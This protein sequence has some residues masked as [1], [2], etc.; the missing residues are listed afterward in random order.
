[1]NDHLTRTP[2]VLVPANSTP[3]E[4][5]AFLER[6]AAALLRKQRYKVTERVRFT[7]ME[8]DLLAEH[9][10]TRQRA[11]VECKFVRDPLSA[12]VI[13]LLRGKAL[14]K[15]AD[16]AYL[17]S[18]AQSGKE[19]RGV[20]DEI[21]HS[22]TDVVPRFA[23]VGPEEIVDSFEDTKGLDLITLMAGR[24]K[25]V[26]SAHLVITPDLPTFWVIEEMVGGL[27]AKALLLGKDQAS[28]QDKIDLIR[29][30][31]INNSIFEGMEINIPLED[32]IVDKN[33]SFSAVLSE[34]VPLVIAADT[35]ID[36][37]PCRP[38]D[39]VGRTELQR[40][41]WQFLENVRK[42]STDTRILAL[43]GQSGF[44]KSS[45]LL[46]LVDRFK[47][48]RWKSKFFLHPVDSRA[49]KGPL[50]I[51][52]A[53]KVTLESAISNGFLQV[54]LSQV[55]VD[56]SESVLDA[57][58]VVRCLEWARNNS[59]V[60]VLFFDQFEEMFYKQ[61][62]FPVF[63]AFKRFAFQVNARKENL[64]LGFSW[65]TGITLPDGNPAYHVWHSLAGIRLNL[66]VGRFLGKESSELVTLFQKALGP[67]FLNPLRRRL[68]EQG[69]GVPW[70]LKKLC[71][72]V[73]REIT[74]GVQQ[75]ELLERRLNIKAI[76]DE[77]LELLTSDKELNCL[78][79]VAT[80]SPVDLN[81][82]I[83]RFG[84]E[85]IRSL[86]E[87][88]LVVRT[89]QK[90]AIYWD[91]FRDYLIESVIPP[92][93][94]TFVPIVPVSM[95]IR[96]FKEIQA[97]GSIDLESLARALGYTQKTTTN[98]VADLQ[99]LV[100]IVRNNDRTYSVQQ[101]L[102]KAGTEDIARY[103][104]DLF[105]DHIATKAFKEKCSA[106]EMISIIEFSSL[107]EE[108]Y[109]G[110]G[111]QPEIARQYARRLNP[112]LRFSGF[113]EIDRE[114]IKRPE[115]ELGK[116]LGV[117]VDRSSPLK[118]IGKWLFFGSASPERVVI[119][120]QRIADQ[121]AMSRQMIIDE[122]NRNAASDLVSIGLAQ[123]AEDALI[124]SNE[125]SGAGPLDYNDYLDLI[126]NTARKTEFVTKAMEILKEQPNIDSTEL[127]AILGNKLEK[128][129]ADESKK[130][131]GGAAKR[132]AKFVGN[133]ER[134]RRL[135]I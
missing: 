34:T 14:R 118:M 48:K 64:V 5:G 36:Y 131:Y 41:V 65:R 21:T 23:F 96:G 52:T 111:V 125:L 135:S 37:R 103:L 129:W 29:T 13:D 117:F 128:K 24:F 126:C 79:Y 15:G 19:A 32:S 83:D 100:L 70:L 11:F 4:K 39:F 55:S 68:I 86:F 58:D 67:R 66:S 116:D 130:R 127:G 115:G 25:G 31:F 62:L 78:K 51:A 54:G 49:A 38:Q 134:Y 22:V 43:S 81:E 88:K 99:N 80:N 33:S 40:E 61:Q 92:I 93:P 120:A 8:I 3:D 1:M 106:G 63:E 95:A 121:Q 16:L 46:K 18:T 113:L 27:P 26:T 76:F 2:L 6:I 47:N 108:A 20:I 132:W 104:H 73:Y 122:S 107:I 59:R 124:P 42:N 91:I 98:I 10:D 71:I 30:L 123:W 57:P 97:A 74:S 84:D 112:W 94:W 75:H 82:V 89:G 102:V 28:L 101:D 53:L 114:R 105:G 87:K 90:Y 7:G 109:S 50:F 77:D 85:I 56:S 69:Q 133:V 45:I 35:L 72:H 60:I 110:G 44:G 9:K 17:F 12:N 119:L